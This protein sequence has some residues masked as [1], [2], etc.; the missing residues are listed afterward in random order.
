VKLFPEKPRTYGGPIYPVQK[1]NPPVLSE[2][3]L[4]LAGF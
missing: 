3:G 2:L 4:K 1:L